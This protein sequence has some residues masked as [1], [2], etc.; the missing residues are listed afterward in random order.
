MNY[1]LHRFFK[2]VTRIR[3]I[4]YAGA[5]CAALALIFFSCSSIPPAGREAAPE[6]EDMLP[7]R[8]SLV[9]IIHGDGDYFYHDTDGNAHKADEV[10]L[11]KAIKV[12]QRNTRTEV[13]IFHEKRRTRFMFIF[14]RRDG[15]FYYYRNGNLIAKESYWRDQGESRFD[16]ETELYNR[17]RAEG[18]PKPVSMFLYFGHEIPEFDGKGYDASYGNRAFTIADLAEGLEGFAQDSTK[19]DLVVL[20]T[21]YNGTPYTMKALAPLARYVIASPDNLHLSYFDLSPFERL[22][23]GLRDEDVFGF[24][25]KFAR[26]AFDRLTEELQTAVTVV[27]YDMEIVLPFTRS[28]AGVYEQTLNSL[29][30]M[31]PG[32]IER[33]DC[34]ED[35]AYAMPG[36]KKGVTVL[37]RA[38]RFGRMKNK[39]SHSGWEC[40]RAVK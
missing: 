16:P 31:A 39:K 2:R 33:C 25:K 4:P 14:P 38:P 5:A 12:A 23:I 30:G 40:W 11:E 20:S 32:S 29:N 26:H 35:S 34:A 24:A 18:S 10:T 8:Y 17:F 36:M 3:T 28:V 9:C 6:V 13:F 27:V 37:Y 22:D 7:P 15:T 21:C 1:M 19:V